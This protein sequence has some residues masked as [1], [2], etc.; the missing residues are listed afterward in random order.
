MAPLASSARRA[1]LLARP[2]GPYRRPVLSPPRTAP[3]RAAPTRGAR[4]PL[5][6]LVLGA[7]TAL[8]AVAFVFAPVRQPEVTY[9]WTPADGTAVA[10]PLMPYQPTR[11]DAAVDCATA[12]RG[13]LLLATVPP[14][15][16]PAAAPLA[17]LTLVGTPAGLTAALTAT[18]AGARLGTVALP[19]GDCTVTLA[20]D[21]AATTVSVDGV[22]V[23]HSPGDVRPDVAGIFT[24]SPDAARTGTGLA[25]SLTADTRFATTPTPLKLAVAAACLAGL[26]ALAAALARADRAAATRRVRVLPAGW[27]RPRPVDGVVAALLL[28]WWVVGAG[29]V[30]D[31][32]VA[33]IVRGREDNGFVGNVYRWL[34]APEAPFSWYDELYHL[35]SQV[36]PA[37]PWM[38]LPST[39]LGLLC[40]GLVS[41]LLLP[42]LG[43]AGRRRA[44]PWVAA[45]AFVTWWVPLNLGLRP[46]PWVAVG[47]VLVVLGVERALATRR[48]LPLAAAL[49]GAGVTTAVTPGGLAAFA[50][51]LAA[52][53]P[54]LRL[55][56]ARTDL[57]LAPGSAAGGPGRALPLLAALAAAPAAALLLMAADQ[58]AAA[59]AEA[60]RVRGLIGGGLPWYQEYER[61]AR[62]LAPDDVQ[63]AIGRRA[64]VLSTV[65]AAA[66]LAWTL[67]TR[68]GPRV[69]VAPAPV[70]RLLVTLALAAGAM[71]FSPTKWTQHFGAL[72]GIGTAVLALGLVAFGGAAQRGF[73]AHDPPTAHRR[74]VAGLAGV[75]VVSGLVLA[76]QNMWP[77]V[78]GWYTPTFSTLPP[79]VTLPGLVADV[80]VATVVVAAGGVVV[81]ALLGRSVWRR[82][83][84]GG[85]RVAPLAPD[86]SSGTLL[87]PRA[88]AFAP[89]RAVPAP[90]APL[91]AVLCAVL[92]LQVLSLVRIAVAHPAGYTPAADALA[93]ASGDPCGLQSALLVETDPADGVL[94]PA[95]PPADPR[96]VVPEPAPPPARPATVDLGGTTAPGIVA[97]GPGA[98]PWYAL[99]P[100]QRGGELPVVVTV[101]G[102]TRPGAEL[103][104]E[105]ARGTRVLARVPL[106]GSVDPADRRLPA[107][108][109]ADAVRLS[110][111]TGPAGTAAP[112]TPTVP[113]AGTAVAS[114]PRVPLLTPMTQVLPRGTR[115]ILDWPVAFV[116][117]C[118]TPEPLPPGTAGLA[119]W[120]V[121]PPSDD[122]AGDITYTPGLGGPFAAPRLLVTQRRMPTYV[123]DDPTR[124]GP[125]LHRW[126]PVVPMRTLRPSVRVREV[127][128]PLPVTH[129]RVPRLK[130]QE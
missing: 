48:V 49:T 67:A 33:G 76:G 13:G 124:D 103:A 59:L 101:V 46:E 122:P 63:G 14:R 98:T 110:V 68:V 7:L 104:A 47:V 100:R 8:A 54:L 25:L 112:T 88:A 95:V 61:Y 121:G 118:L 120:R 119:R 3:R 19:A 27:W 97:V 107:P 51:V 102:T 96:P 125:L 86:A 82:S 80:P 45:L 71:T 79:L 73:A 43:R 16:D 15:P 117:P 90:A 81:A 116:F 113:D 60:V 58:G 28:L 57:Q 38:R 108:P 128:T 17:G 2:P 9:A 109:D 32:Y 130:E 52:A 94:P 64:A 93:T 50:P 92:T 65:L 91:A 6:V 69:G 87:A 70:R 40:W 66:G 11:L 42:R 84:E 74:L 111:T 89:P 75:T 127:V 83:G 18:S 4:R 99:D 12:R 30:D 62:L 55:L 5:L 20:S 39:L 23:L 53:V 37:T 10:L 106:A 105:F 126:D 115:A 77:F 44:M 34:N 36:S 123:R 29:T 1:T 56:R 41:R 24:E 35:W 78:S 85:S 21:A 129:L 72:T 114:L 31:G 22:T 26:A